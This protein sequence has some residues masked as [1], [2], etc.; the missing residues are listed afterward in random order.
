MLTFQEKKENNYTTSLVIIFFRLATILRC[1]N[2]GSSPSR[3]AVIFMVPLALFTLIIICLM[4]NIHSAKYWLSKWTVYI[5][6]SALPPCQYSKYENWTFFSHWH[7][8]LLY[9]VLIDYVSSLS[10]HVF[11]DWPFHA[12]LSNHHAIL[13]NYTSW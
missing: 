7:Q 4:D 13:T 5:I 2:D 10:G 3:I 9:H 11:Q 6:N 1:Y 8:I 12:L